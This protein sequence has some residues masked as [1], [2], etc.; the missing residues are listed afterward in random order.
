LFQGNLEKAQIRQFHFCSEAKL[1]WRA[2]NKSFPEWF[3]FSDSLPLG[4]AFRASLKEDGLH[5]C[6]KRKYVSTAY[7]QDFR[8]SS[9]IAFIALIAQH[10]RKHA[11]KCKNIKL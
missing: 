5:N 9:G 7:K 1:L 11:A 3:N 10:G 8:E 2:R 4:V 6:D